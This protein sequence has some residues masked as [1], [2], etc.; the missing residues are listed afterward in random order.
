MQCA[1]VLADS[2]ALCDLLQPGN[3]TRLHS[4][5]EWRGVLGRLLGC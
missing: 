3:L 5:W 1:V 2:S 4:N